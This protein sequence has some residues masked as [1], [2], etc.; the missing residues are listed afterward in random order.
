MQS[1]G[2]RQISAPK[3]STVT[4]V[5]VMPAS[6]TTQVFK[7]ANTTITAAYAAGVTSIA[8]AERK[9]FYASQVVLLGYGA[10]SEEQVTVD[11]GYSPATGA[12]SVTVSATKKAHAKN[13]KVVEKLDAIV[14]G[15]L[16]VK[17]T[18]T[19]VATDDGEGNLVEVASSGISGTVD[20][21]AGLVSIDMGSSSQRTI[22]YN[23]DKLND[24]ADINDQKGDGFMRNLQIMEFSP[25]DGPT[26]VIAKNL[27]V[28]AVG[29]IVE[30]SSN[31]G[32]SF[33]QL[34]GKSGTLSSLAKKALTLPALQGADLVRVRASAAS[35]GAGSVLELDT[36]QDISDNGQ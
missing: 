20:Y 17:S 9:G 28:S 16:N 1:L 27:G 5:A 30:K 13:E 34:A 15:T 8:V 35:G 36:L 21:S 24:S 25:H 7:N 23:A 22:T 3:A 10:D 33:Q 26:A 4:A 18:A 29:F 14:P 2:R 12:G 31:G 6:T 19:S 11:S 32:K